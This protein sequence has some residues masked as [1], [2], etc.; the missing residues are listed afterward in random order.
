MAGR[1]FSSETLESR[2]V[3]VKSGLTFETGQS[4]DAAGKGALPLSDA[5]RGEGNETCDPL[6]VGA[7]S[8]RGP[9]GNDNRGQTVGSC[10]FN[11][12]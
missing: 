12:I 5:V 8:A 11:H 1:T 6:P 4:P 10:W 3:N 9:G 7:T 2:D